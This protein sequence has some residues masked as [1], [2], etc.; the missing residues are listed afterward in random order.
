MKTT[1]KE[2]KYI[3][4][5]WKNDTGYFNGSITQCEFEAMLRYRF[6]FG[7]AETNVITMSLILAGAKFA[8]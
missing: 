6:G 1:K 3:L 2:A 5:L 7:E 8:L 4:D